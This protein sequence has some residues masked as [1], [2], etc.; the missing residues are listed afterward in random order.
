M[1]T[2]LFARV[3]LAVVGEVVQFSGVRQP[4]RLL[5]RS[6]VRQRMSDVGS[7]HGR[8]VIQRRCRHV[9]R[10]IG[11]HARSDGR[12]ATDVRRPVA[13]QTVERISRWLVDVHLMAELGR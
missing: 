12:R 6:D 5:L 4:H 10:I 8:D 9:R 7:S 3:L 13:G 2:L 11:L 1:A